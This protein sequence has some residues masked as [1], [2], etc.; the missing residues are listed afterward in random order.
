MHSGRK[1]TG[2]RLDEFLM[3]SVFVWCAL[4]VSTVKVPFSLTN[5]FK[6]MLQRGVEL[7]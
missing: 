3:R 6:G 7:R 1:Q 2:K 4:C 5:S